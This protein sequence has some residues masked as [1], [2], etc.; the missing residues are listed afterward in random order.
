MIE[1]SAQVSVYPLRQ[2][3]LSP[4][5]DETVGICRAHGLQVC[6]GP[7]STLVT[8]DDENLFAALKE[9]LRSAAA[10]G[11][12]VM[13]VTL[14]NACPAIRQADR[15]VASPESGLPADEPS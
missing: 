6:P 2:P 1:V 8:G 15:D 3:R 5:I 14:S 7:M 13:V 10:R 4:T 12:V 9:A 11:N